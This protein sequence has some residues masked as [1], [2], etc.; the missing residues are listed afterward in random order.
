MKQLETE[1]KKKSKEL[2]QEDLKKVWQTIKKDR[3]IFSDVSDI[4]EYL[5]LKFKQ[6]TQ[7]VWFNAWRHEKSESLWA[8]FAISFLEQLSKN[9]NLYQIRLIAHTISA[10]SSQ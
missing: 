10:S 5:K 2:D 1:V 6:E 3:I 9:P 7:T 8:T 4:W